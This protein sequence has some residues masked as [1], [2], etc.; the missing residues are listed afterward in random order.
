MMGNNAA[1]KKLGR[2][3]IVRELGKGAMG[4]VYEGQDPS[5]GRR[6]AIK[7]AR[8]DMMDRPDLA[9]ELMERFLREARAA[10]VLNHPNIITIYDVGEEEG[11]AYIAMEFL[12]GK[13]LNTIIEEQRRFDVQTVVH[14][15]VQI[16]DALTCAHDQ[17][18]VHRDV[19]PANIF[20][21]DQGLIKVVDFGIARTHDSTLTQEGAIIGTP[22]YMSPEQF[23]GQRVD[24]R[25]D[26][27]ALGI[28]LYE[29]LTGEKPFSGEALTTIMH[30]ILKSEPASPHELNYL[31]PEALGEAVMRALSKKPQDRYPDGYA[32]SLALKEGL[33]DNPNMDLILGKATSTQ[34]TVVG[35]APPGAG[36]QELPQK[37]KT[38]DAVIEGSTVTM[39]GQQSAKA[40][41]DAPATVIS[42]NDASITNASTTIQP[43]GMSFGQLVMQHNR[44]VLGGVA[45]LCLVAG[46]GLYLF[47]PPPQEPQGATPTGTV[48]NEPAA[49]PPAEMSDRVDVGVYVYA[50]EDWRVATDFG[51]KQRE[52][53]D[54]AAWIESL[55]TGTVTAVQAA[56]LAVR[57][58]HPDQADLVYGERELPEG[59]GS[60]PVPRNVSRVR[61]DI[62]LGDTSL[63]NV[64][65]RIDEEQ[66]PEA[67]YFVVR[68]GDL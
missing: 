64:E 36:P 51:N 31:V 13:D 1:P 6:V 33:K 58:S 20:V 24:A 18:V 23:M 10:G 62:L 34:E 27:F 35:I 53:A 46:L 49:P 37:A 68:A 43:K 41:E 28:I 59:Y 45:V 39:M 67:Q 16:C 48:V 15:G 42:E 4:I 5:L 63:Y 55:E 22:S 66:G 56:G 32:M 61:Y 30:H 11:I 52:G 8:R 50:T 26:L 29:M 9:E 44:L 3:E 7:T 57:A 2:Y 65:I 21:P 54:I 17:G 38:G 60:V 12:E 40:A 14:Y 25:S 47:A 19:K